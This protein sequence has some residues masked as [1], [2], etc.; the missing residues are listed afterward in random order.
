MATEPVLGGSRRGVAAPSV[1]CDEF[2]LVRPVAALGRR[3]GDDGMGWRAVTWLERRLGLVQLVA[4]L[5]GVRFNSRDLVPNSS[6]M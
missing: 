2:G 5:T 3:S 1:R 4:N 6:A